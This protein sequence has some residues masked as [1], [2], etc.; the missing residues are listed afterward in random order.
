M[1]NLPYLN[2]RIDEQDVVHMDGLF[3]SAHLSKMLILAGIAAPDIEAAIHQT[4]K[5]LRTKKSRIKKMRLNIELV[6]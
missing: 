3:N 4:S 6:Q 1:K 5:H 2:L